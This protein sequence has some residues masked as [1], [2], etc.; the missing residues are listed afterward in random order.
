MKITEQTTIIASLKMDNDNLIEENE[1]W[2]SVVEK[3][4]QNFTCFMDNLKRTAT[5][6][7]ENLIL[8]QKIE[9]S[10]TVRNITLSKR[11]VSRIQM[12]KLWI[13]SLRKITLEK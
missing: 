5:L 9:E 6:E 10:N 1:K 3:Y 4:M 11:N 2:K 8:Q 7:Q 13:L 12:K